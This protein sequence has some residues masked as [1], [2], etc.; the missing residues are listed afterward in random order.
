MKQIVELGH[1]SFGLT[2]A[3]KVMKL[4]SSTELFEGKC[5]IGISVDQGSNYRSGY[6]INI[7]AAVFDDGTASLYTTHRYS[8]GEVI[9]LTQIL[10]SGKSGIFV[11]AISIHFGAILVRTNDRLI[12]LKHAGY[13]DSPLSVVQRIKHRSKYAAILFAGGRADSPVV[14]ALGKKGELK[15]RALYNVSKAS[16]VRL[17][18][19]QEA[20]ARDITE[21]EPADKFH[22]IAIPSAVKQFS[23]SGDHVLAVTERGELWGWGAN[24]EGKLGI[25]T[26][27]DTLSAPRMVLAGL[28]IVHAAAGAEHSVVATADGKLYSSGRRSKGRLGSRD[29]KGNQNTFIEMNTDGY[30]KTQQIG[31]TPIEISLAKT[32]TIVLFKKS[33]AALP[34]TTV[35]ATPELQE[36]QDSQSTLGSLTL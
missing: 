34:R 17:E 7:L 21:G 22:T 5:C 20:L 28:D 4:Y 2:A 11:L 18:K 24:K 3:G 16:G 9:N 1:S 32:S 35:E 14:F 13:G 12:L 36:A 25:I 31:A 15:S 26:S 19:L 29:E 27:V 30:Q 6:T 8:Q 23:S 10:K 33:E